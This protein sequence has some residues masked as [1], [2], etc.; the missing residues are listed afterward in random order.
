MPLSQASL[1]N[2]IPNF[3]QLGKNHE[4]AYEIL[5]VIND[6]FGALLA[7]LAR[8][9]GRKLEVKLYFSAFEF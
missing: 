4:L 8:T 9:Y 2:H 7:L 1:R 3:R 5:G 6:Y